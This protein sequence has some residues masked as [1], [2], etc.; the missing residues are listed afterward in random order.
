[1]IT[2]PATGLIDFHKAGDEASKEMAR[3]LE[4]SWLIVSEW[5]AEQQRSG[6]TR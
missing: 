4:D 2:A 6:R 3:Q 5:C 1:V